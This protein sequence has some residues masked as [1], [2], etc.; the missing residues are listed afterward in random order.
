MDEEE[1]N[2]AA[3][4]NQNPVGDEDEMPP[5]PIATSGVMRN[6]KFWCKVLQWPLVAIFLHIVIFSTLLDLHFFWDDPYNSY[7]NKR[8]RG[9]KI[10]PMLRMFQTNT[11]VLGVVLAVDT[12]FVY[13]VIRFLEK[14]L[15]QHYQVTAT[16]ANRSIQ[17]EYSP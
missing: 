11:A 2:R 17:H 9:G 10:D 3:A 12:F 16:G 7:A 13:K 5:P 8:Y 6:V 15:S 4:H 1:A 14:D